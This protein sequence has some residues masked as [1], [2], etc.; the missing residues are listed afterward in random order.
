MNERYDDDHA[1][2][3]HCDGRCFAQVEIRKVRAANMTEIC[4]PVRIPQKFCLGI[5]FQYA[6]TFC[7]LCAGVS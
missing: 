5:D 3:C 1:G 6:E 4:R 7:R 2:V